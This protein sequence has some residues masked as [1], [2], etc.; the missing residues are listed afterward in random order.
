MTCTEQLATFL[1]EQAVKYETADFIAA[2]PVQ[3]PHRYTDAHD[4]EVSAFIS[5]WLAYGNRKAFIRVLDSLHSI[6][7]AAGGPWRYVNGTEWTQYSDSEQVLYRFNKWGDFAT[8]C[9]YLHDFYAVYPS[10]QILGAGG[11]AMTFVTKLALY[12]YGVPGI[13]VPGSRSANKRIWMFLRWMV[14]RDSAVDFGIWTNMSPAELLVP[15][16][17]HVLQSA[18]KL[19]LA[20]SG[21]ASLSFAVNLTA[22]MDQVFPGDPARADFALFSL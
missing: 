2:D 10:L 7:D 9:C 1:R 12:M 20:D 8:L 11:N 15:V 6:M 13:P 3:F 14:R 22:I 5:Q 16:D 19:G 21:T 17:T 4:I 18:I